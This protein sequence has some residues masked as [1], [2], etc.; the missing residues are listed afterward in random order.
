M[1]QY[2]WIQLEDLANNIRAIRDFHF[3]EFPIEIMFI[4]LKNL[5]TI[6]QE[7]RNFNITQNFLTKQG[8]PKDQEQQELIKLQN[9]P[10]EVS[11]IKV[12]FQSIKDLTISLEAMEQINNFLEV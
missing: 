3:L 6:E 4:L 11:L 1:E 10:I 8:L 2:T 5:K 12:P 9:F 7:I